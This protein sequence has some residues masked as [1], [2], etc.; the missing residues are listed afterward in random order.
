[1]ATLSRFFLWRGALVNV[2]ADTLIRWHG[3]GFR[4]FWRWKSKPTE[5]LRSPE[6]YD[7]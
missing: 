3:K 4:L 5:D 7:N 1:M 6:T 2:R